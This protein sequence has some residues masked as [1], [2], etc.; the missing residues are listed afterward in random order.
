M[1][2][3]LGDI[4]DLNKVSDCQQVIRVLLRDLQRRCEDSCSDKLK[5]LTRLVLSDNPR[6]KDIAREIES[7]SKP[8]TPEELVA[9]LERMSDSMDRAE[10]LTKAELVDE[11]IKLWSRLPMDS[12]ESAI[13]DETIQRLK[14]ARAFAD[15]SA[16]S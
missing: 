11:A 10:K 9:F 14:K 5:S 7:G 1:E 6:A 15:D 2:K 4:Y 16:G 12:W 13:L 3:R 8:R